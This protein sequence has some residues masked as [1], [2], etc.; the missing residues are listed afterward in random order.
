MFCLLPFHFDSPF[1]VFWARFLI[2]PLRSPSN[3]TTPSPSDLLLS[4]LGTIYLPCLYVLCRRSYQRTLTSSFFLDRF[5]VHAI[6]TVGGGLLIGVVLSCLVW[7]CQLLYI[8]SFELTESKP[9]IS[10]RIFLQ[11]S[12]ARLLRVSE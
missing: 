10:L 1:A 7:A 5:V 8:W 2:Y 9:F 12:G 11:S 3:P 4:M 6:G